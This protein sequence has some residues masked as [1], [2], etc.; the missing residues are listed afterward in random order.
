MGQKKH[1]NEAK[2][3]DKK[4]DLETMDTVKVDKGVSSLVDRAAEAAGKLMEQAGAQV[5]EAGLKVGVAGEKL[6]QAGRDLKAHH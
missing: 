4:T 3:D 1:K 2:N 5:E 6:A